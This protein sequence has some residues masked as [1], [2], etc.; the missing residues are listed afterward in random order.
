MLYLAEAQSLTTA[1]TDLTDDSVKVHTEIPK[2]EEKANPIPLPEKNIKQTEKTTDTLPSIEYDI[3]K[4]PAPVKMMRQKIIDAAKTGDVNNL[5]PLLGTSGDP[6]QLSVS[7]NVKDPITYLKQ[8]SGDGDGLEIMAIMIDL[9]NSGYAHLD[10]G[11]DEEIY[12]WP[13]FVALPIDKLSKPQLVE[14]FQIM[15]A[16]D[17]EEMKE[18]GTY[19]FFRIGITPDGT[20]RF[21]ITGD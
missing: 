17:L 3:E 14:L 13:Y 5:K 4:L 9:L 19:S 20:W 7:D 11:D 18:I 1:S 6:T 15:T 16:G 10:Q 8:L 21:F 2:V 12:I